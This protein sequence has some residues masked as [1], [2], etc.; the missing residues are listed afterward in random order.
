MEFVMTATKSYSE[1]VEWAYRGEV[2]GELMLTRL[3]DLGA[4]PEEREHLEMLLELESRTRQRLETLVDLSTARSAS[5]IAQQEAAD[6]SDEVIRSA[7]WH[8]FMT[9]TN[10]I[11]QSALPELVALRAL[12]PESAS[13]VL[14]EVVDHE[15]VVVE[16]SALRLTG[17]RADALAC[18]A[19]HLARE[20]EAW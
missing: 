1:L 14:D 12:G 20:T 11:A 9:E 7:D 18:V 15:R 8:A 2:W 5:E 6:Y 17:N 16:Y 19:H 4:F 10:E 3:L 13:D